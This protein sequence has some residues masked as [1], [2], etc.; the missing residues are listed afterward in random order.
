MT[1][2]SEIQC[3]RF[4]L[5]RIKQKND[6][7]IYINKKTDTLQKARQFALHF[8]SQKSR[9]LKLRDFR[10][11]FEIGIYIYTKIMTLCVTGRFLYK[12]PDTLKKARQSVL[13]FYSQKSRHFALR[14]F[15]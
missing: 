12:K 7:F 10:E 14:D 11:L 9:H 6:T 2:I 15:S 13:H 3:A 5:T 4:L 8:Y 1:P